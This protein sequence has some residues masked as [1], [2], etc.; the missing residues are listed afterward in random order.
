MRPALDRRTTCLPAETPEAAAAPVGIAMQRA[1]HGAN[2]SPE[3]TIQIA[4]ARRDALRDPAQAAMLLR[5][6]MSDHD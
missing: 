3:L 6:W 5:A 1:L 2:E 4:R